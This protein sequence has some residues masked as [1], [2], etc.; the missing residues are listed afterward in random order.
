V[1]KGLDYTEGCLGLRP[2]LRVIDHAR[3]SER[4]A[5]IMYLRDNQITI[6]AKDGGFGR[7]RWAGTF[8]SHQRW[9]TIHF[10]VSS[11]EIVNIF[12]SWHLVSSV[13]GVAHKYSNVNN[14]ATKSLEYKFITNSQQFLFIL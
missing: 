11:V 14:L 3:G 9:R 13:N 5:N 12:G 1:D 10:L 4:W 6:P 7:Y 2:P 8:I